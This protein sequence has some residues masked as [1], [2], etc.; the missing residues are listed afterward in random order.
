MKTKT[1]LI[2]YTENNKPVQIMAGS[3]VVPATNL[4]ES[5]WIKFW[6]KDCPINAD[7]QVESHFR[8]IGFGFEANEVTI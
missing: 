6:L 8:N 5:S 7:D 2:R 3:E 4:P 1:N